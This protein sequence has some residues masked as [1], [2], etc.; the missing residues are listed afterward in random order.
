MN[1]VPNPSEMWRRQHKLAWIVITKIFAVKLLS[2]PFLGHHLGFHTF[3]TMAFLGAAHFFYSLAV[4]GLD[5][6]SFCMLQSCIFPINGCC[7]L[8]F[9]SCRQVFAVL[10]ICI[11]HTFYL[12]LYI[13]ISMITGWFKKQLNSCSSFE[14][15]LS[16]VYWVTFNQAEFSK[17]DL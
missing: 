2:Q 3:F 7:Y 4:F 5:F 16:F 10:Y 12:K 11:M 14:L 1:S 17:N 8:S 13:C 9:F 15:L 6:T